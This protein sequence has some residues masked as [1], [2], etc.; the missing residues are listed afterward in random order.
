M[1]SI[2]M[3]KKR[4]FFGSHFQFS[5]WMGYSDLKNNARGIKS[6]FKELSN[7]ESGD[8]LKETFEEA[9]S[10][11]NLTNDQ[12]VQ[13]TMHFLKLAIF[14]FIA[15]FLIFCYGLYLYFSKDYIGAFMC[16]PVFSVLL[17]FSFKEHFWYTQMK[18]RRLGF[19]AKEWFASLLK[20]SKSEN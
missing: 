1:L 15:A 17:S 18:H 13:R 9:A 20:G 8:F 19:T 3:A 6:L 4:G 10:R 7:Q 14:Y 11:L 5:R 16:L 2:Y 12:I